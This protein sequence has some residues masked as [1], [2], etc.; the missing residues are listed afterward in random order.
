LQEPPK[1]TQIG[2]SGFKICHLAILNNTPPAQLFSCVHFRPSIDPGASDPASLFHRPALQGS[3]LQNS[4]SA[5]NF[6]G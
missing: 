6:F 2:I 4:I 3:I 5:E 1:F